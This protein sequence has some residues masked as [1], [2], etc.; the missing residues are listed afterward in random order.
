MKKIVIP[1]LLSGLLI[2]G[3][4]GSYS[5][6]AGTMGDEE[7]LLFMDIP[8]VVTASKSETTLAKAPS[9]VTVWTADDIQKMGIRSLREL[10]ER[11]S[12]FFCTRQYAAAVFGS[13]GLIGDSNTAFLFLIDG[14]SIN[15]IA[16]DG[17]SNYWYLP[18]LDKVKQVEIVRGP[19]STLWGTDA[20][21]ATINIIT[22]DGS[23]VN[24]LQ[25][26]INAASNDGQH[27]A[28]ILY[29]KD[30]GSKKSVM[31]SFTVTAEN[32]FPYSTGAT[33]YPA[34]YAWVGGNPATDH[35]APLDAM[36]N[37]YEFHTKVKMDDL[38]ISAHA[39]NVLSTDLW[40]RNTDPNK[41][42]FQRRE[43]TYI[44]VANDSKL[45]DTLSLTTKFFTD[46]LVTDDHMFN[47]ITSPGMTGVDEES[48]S[49]EQ[50]VGLDMLFDK[51]FKDVDDLKFGVRGVMTNLDPLIT[52]NGLNFS[53][54]SSNALNNGGL[55]LIALPN[56]YD[57]DFAVFA[58]NDWKATEKLDIIFGIRADNDNLLEN[59][60]AYLPRLAGIY[61]FDQ[62]STLKYCYNTGYVR[63]E[64]GQGYFGQQPIKIF[65]MNQ[66]YG[67]PTKPTY[68]TPGTQ[69]RNYNQIGADK[70]EEIYTHDLDYI[71]NTKTFSGSI[72]F[73][74]TIMK[75]YFNYDG[76]FET[77]NGQ[78]DGGSPILGANGL[79][80]RLAT[81]NANTITSV[82]VEIDAKKKFN[83]GV[84]VYGNVSQIF[85][86][87]VDSFVWQIGNYTTTLQGNALYDNNKNV[88]AFPYTTFN[89]GT[90]I[91]LNKN[92]ALNIHLNGF[93]NGYMLKTQTGNPTTCVYETIPFQ[94][95][96]DVNV[97]FKDILS[98]KAL[99]ASVFV[100]NLLNN[101]KAEVPMVDAGG[102]NYAEGISLGAKISYRFTGI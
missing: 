15:S 27:T 91:D 18:A 42:Y 38:T 47:F 82:G 72:D 36:P 83:G 30:Y 11:T 21:M 80:N 32:G 101:D 43:T 35:V 86:A 75:N 90:D 5:F 100:K 93:G 71:Y 78:I 44:E 8:S 88:C 81:V 67:D 1:A 74:Q 10:F 61:A 46:Y 70:A 92:I 19:G 59:K 34:N 26:S 24:G 39:S 52:Y 25:I 57:K 31:V 97:L 69:L 79:P 51:K 60:T 49:K 77:A 99:T 9:V 76:N 87:Q 65:D 55:S 85:S 17:P 53:S 28:N 23:D 45:S 3:L 95:F 22:K 37:S 64:A 12:G 96:V 29:G 7:S 14:H 58:E 73:Y 94:S 6:A 89:A 20:A 84:E 4:A 56:D 54:L 2:S 33:I 66:E 40:Q 102:F 13:H 62:S 98:N 48:L 16:M 63:P 41:Q 50:K 68:I